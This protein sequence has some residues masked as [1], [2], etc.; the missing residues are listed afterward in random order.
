M[1]RKELET[2]ASQQLIAMKG[3]G[4]YARNTEG[5]ARMISSQKDIFIDLL[6]RTPAVGAGAFVIADYGAADGGTSL[7]L[8]GDAVAAQ[9]AR[10]PLRPVHVIYTDLPS[11]DFGFLFRTLAGQEDGFASYL[12][13]HA[14]TASAC[15]ISFHEAILPPESV[16]LAFSANAMHWLRDPVPVIQNHVHSVGA[17]GSV[18]KQLSAQGLA[19]WRRLL[20]LRGQELR[21]GG[22]LM[23][24][25]F[26]RSEDG[27]HLGKTPSS[28]GIFD[29]LNSIWAEM[30]NNGL[31]TG[32]EYANTNFAQYYMT[33]SEVRQPFEADEAPGGLTLLDCDACR[34]SCMYR[35]RYDRDGDAETFAA[36]FVPNVRSWSERTFLNGLSSSRPEAERLALVDELYHRYANRVRAHPERHHMDYYFARVICRKADTSEPVA[37]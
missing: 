35:S 6:C 23:I 4:Y 27:F 28:D 34:F 32:N 17:E 18:L 33:L 14:V 30:R 3:H 31:I 12:S 36:T 26:I 25:T 8:I 7:D 1:E 11:A 16:D 9:R 19:D 24:L 13:G 21:S 29:T 22:H 37:A 5:A 15:G 2:M 20:L 10:E